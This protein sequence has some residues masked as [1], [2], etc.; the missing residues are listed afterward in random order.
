MATQENCGRGHPAKK[1][2]P[3]AGE[4]EEALDLILRIAG[5][6]EDSASS[7]SDP[8]EDTIHQEAQIH[9]QDTSGEEV[10]NVVLSRQSVRRRL[11]LTR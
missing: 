4:D 11:F 10:E 1:K 5:G 9:Q 2:W 7:D 8:A 3:Q 6:G